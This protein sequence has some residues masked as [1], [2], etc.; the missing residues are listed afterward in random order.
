MKRAFTTAR[1]LLKRAPLIETRQDHFRR[2]ALMQ[3]IVTIK[4]FS[5]G[6]TPRPNPHRRLP[7][8]PPRRQAPLQEHDRMLQR[9]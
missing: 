7:G 5:I 3:T 2:H 1:L 8:L 6:R 9:G 4:A